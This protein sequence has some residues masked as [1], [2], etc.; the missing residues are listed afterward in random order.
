MIQTNS[1]KPFRKIEYDLAH[2][3]DKT[4]SLWP[5]LK[6]SEIFITGGTGFFGKWLLASIVWANIHLNTKIKAVVLTRNPEGFQKSIP[7]L[8][9]N[10]NIELLEGDVINFAFPVGRFSHIIHAATDASANLNA[11]NPLLM[12]DTI[13][14]GTRRVLEFAVENKTSRVLMISSG[15]IYGKQSPG[16]RPFSEKYAGAPDITSHLSAYGE[17]KRVAELLGA[18][19]AK[20]HALQVVTARC[21]AFVGPYLNLDIHYA[22]GNF[23]RDGLNGG[24][25]IVKGDGTA[26]RSYMYAADLVVWLLTILLRGESGKAYNVGSDQEISIGALAKLVSNCFPEKQDVRIVGVRK[27]GALAERYIPDIQLAGNELG[28]TVEVSLEDAIRRT[29]KWH[30]LEA[31]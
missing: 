8:A 11:E 24:P 1:Y 12:F 3:L 23:I 31:V 17:A 16:G 4:S 6:G 21:F 30:T 18:M 7:D 9:N 5:L 26:C 15:G 27:V 13:V 2:I 19:Y 10:P 25:I 22:V 20:Q 14:Q 29:V 28:L